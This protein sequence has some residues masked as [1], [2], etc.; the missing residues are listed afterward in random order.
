MAMKGFY[1]VLYF[2]LQ[3]DDPSHQCLMLSTL[4]QCR[5]TVTLPVR[6]NVP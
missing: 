3:F 5:L 1:D 2:Y 4:K 6:W